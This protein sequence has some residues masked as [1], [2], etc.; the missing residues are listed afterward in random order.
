MLVEYLEVQREDV[1][2][3]EQTLGVSYNHLSTDCAVPV[4]DN[5]SNRSTE[6]TTTDLSAVD[7]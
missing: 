7:A 3:G 1:W 2:V 5:L 6:A 4:Q